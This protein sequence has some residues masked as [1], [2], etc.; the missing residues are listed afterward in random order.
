MGRTIW[1]SA[2]IHGQNDKD[3]NIVTAEELIATMAQH[4][5]EIGLRMEPFEKNRFA[6]DTSG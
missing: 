2:L 4:I 1:R 6:L 5:P 3:F